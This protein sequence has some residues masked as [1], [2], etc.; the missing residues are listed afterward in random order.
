MAKQ[1]Q[2]KSQ[3]QQERRAAQR[4]LKEQQQRERR[5]RWFISGGVVLLIVLIVGGVIYYNATRPQDQT[6]NNPSTSNDATTNPVY[7]PVDDISCDAQ[8]QLNYHIHAHLSLYIDGQAVAIPQNIGIASD[9]SCIYWLHSHDSTGI[10]HVESPTTRT[11]T[12]GNFLTIWQQRFSSLGYPTQLKQTSGW[13]IYVDGKEYTGD[14]HDIK[15][16]AHTLITMG[17]NSPN[18]TPDTSYNWGKL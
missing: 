6:T 2:T 5:N 14:F 3:R 13:K 17:Y 16:N 7:A 4:R 8:E 9:G 1:H 10:I 12:L 11:Y 18:I 15:I